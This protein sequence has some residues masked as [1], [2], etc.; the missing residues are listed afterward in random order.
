[1]LYDLEWGVGEGI[2]DW[3]V[4]IF[5]SKINDVWERLELLATTILSLQGDLTWATLRTLC[6]WFWLLSSYGLHSISLWWSRS[7]F[8]ATT[9]QKYLCL[10]WRS[11]SFM[12]LCSC[13]HF[14]SLLNIYIDAL[15]PG[16]PSIAAKTTLSG[17]MPPNLVT[18]PRLW[19]SLK[20]SGQA[21]HSEPWV[22]VEVPIWPEQRR[23]GMHNVQLIPS[24]QMMMYIHIPICPPTWS[25]CPC[26][27]GPLLSLSRMHDGV[28]AL[29]PPVLN[30]MDRTRAKVLLEILGWSFVVIC[31]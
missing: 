12:I 11:S 10:S 18:M 6:G 28:T 31:L 14:P 7:P 5:K 2:D 20:R 16:L 25:M 22:V 4:C 1:M 29:P 15:K 19:T 9:L 3:V 23:W 21:S 26:G 8:Y 24:E 17:S 30:G 13:D 27:L